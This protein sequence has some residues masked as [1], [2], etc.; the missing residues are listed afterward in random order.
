MKG[1][2]TRNLHAKSIHS[3]PIRRCR[4]LH[5]QAPQRRR[6]DAG[7]SGWQR[8]EWSVDISK[9]ESGVRRLDVIEL[10]T[11]ATATLSAARTFVEQL[12][13]TLAVPAA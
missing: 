1:S 4:P 7:Q 10:R 11:L 5:R 12:E 6:A 2:A 8:L 9:V 13:Q 3:Q